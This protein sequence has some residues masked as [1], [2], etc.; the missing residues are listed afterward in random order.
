[1]F[2]AQETVLCQC[3]M[4]EWESSSICISPLHVP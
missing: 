3:S 1:M 4:F 2:G